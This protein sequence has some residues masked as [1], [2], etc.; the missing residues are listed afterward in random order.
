MTKGFG[1]LLPGFVNL[2][3]SDHEAIK[4]LISDET[5]AI[6]IEPIQGEGVLE[7]ATRNMFK[8]NS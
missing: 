7:Y 8:G 6:L 4:S 5:A 2:D 1:P 3:W